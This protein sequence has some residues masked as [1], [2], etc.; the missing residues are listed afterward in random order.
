MEL[1]IVPSYA[2]LLAFGLI[3]LSLRVIGLRRRLKVSLGTGGEADLERAVRVQGNFS[4]YVPLAVVLLSFVELGGNPHW[5]V[6][7]LCGLLLVGRA[8]HAAGLSGAVEDHRYRV[9]GMAAT[10][11]VL[12]VASTLL[13]TGGA[14]PLVQWKKEI[15]NLLLA[16]FNMGDLKFLCLQLE[17]EYE[18]LEHDTRRELAMSI[19]Q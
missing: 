14:L 10:F 12:A 18:D 8:V 3:L 16:G 1:T 15:V 6:H 11:T 4:E 17:V 19:V 7:L 13:L 5:A 9:F 2:A